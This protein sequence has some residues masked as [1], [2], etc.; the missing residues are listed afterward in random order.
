MRTPDGQA[1]AERDHLQIADL[2]ANMNDQAPVDTT[3]QWKDH[4]RDYHAANTLV[5]EIEAR[6]GYKALS[7]HTLKH[8]P[9]EILLIAR[10]KVTR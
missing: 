10:M 6:S 5:R 8:K 7:V 2:A 9:G 3:P 1:M 4:P